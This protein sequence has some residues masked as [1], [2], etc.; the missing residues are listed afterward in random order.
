[1]GNLL[2]MTR[3]AVALM[4]KASTTNARP[5]ASYIFRMSSN[6]LSIDFLLLANLLAKDHVSAAALRA[7]FISLAARC[8]VLGLANKSTSAMSNAGPSFTGVGAVW[9]TQGW[10]LGFFLLAAPRIL[11][12]A[13]SLR[14]MGRALGLLVSERRPATLW[15]SKH[16]V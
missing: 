6:K 12:K 16:P 7:N 10:G 9:E 4:R 2:R 14:W 15:V 13:F 1:M 11:E 8:T 5:Q 3:M